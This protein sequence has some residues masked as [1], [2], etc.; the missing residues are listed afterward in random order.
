MDFQLNKKKSLQ[1]ALI[2]FFSLIPLL[3][4]SQNNYKQYEFQISSIESLDLTKSSGYIVDA[5]TGNYILSIND[6]SIKVTSIRTDS[7]I[8]S[9]PRPL[10]I[11]YTLNISFPDS[12]HFCIYSGNSFWVFQG[13]SL[14]EYFLDPKLTGFQ[15]FR[16]TVSQYFPRNNCI[17]FNILPNNCKEYPI[18]KHYS[19]PAF[20]SLDLKTGQTKILQIVASE[21][22]WGHKLDIPYIYTSQSSDKYLLVSYSYDEFIYKYDINREKLQRIELNYSGNQLKPNP[23]SHLKGTEAKDAMQKSWIAEDSY[24]NAFYNEETNT[25]Y[26]IYKPSIPLKTDG[27]IYM[28]ND[29]KPAHIIK[30]CN[31]TISHYFLPMGIFTYRY[32]WFYSDI[33]DKISY[34]RLT[35]KK[36]ES[37]LFD[38]DYYNVILYDF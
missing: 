24:L 1:I 38:L 16:A 27:G 14:H 31:E 26:R 4:C 6:D 3:S 33:T 20:A 34:L 7:T 22:Y 21:K 25:F 2:G 32:R 11:Q 35:K 36:N 23:T 10:E 28:T 17:I 15:V 19:W 29:N 18:E 12:L 9:I 8:H 37:K 30:K 5:K 13:D